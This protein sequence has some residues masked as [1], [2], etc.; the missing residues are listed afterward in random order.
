M[1][2]QPIT[3][4]GIACATALIKISLP[5]LD[6]NLSFHPWIFLPNTILQV[7]ENITP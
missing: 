2:K 4:T 5:A 6:N 7:G 1:S 3:K